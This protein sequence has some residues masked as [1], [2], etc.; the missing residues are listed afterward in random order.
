MA[1]VLHYFATKRSVTCPFPSKGGQGR[2]KEK[3]SHVSRSLTG[4]LLYA[5]SKLLN[6]LENWKAFPLKAKVPPLCYT[7][8]LEVGLIFACGW[9][10]CPWLSM[11]QA[12]IIWPI[13]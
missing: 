13:E 9:K 1:D 2:F 11:N 6:D 8:L 5:L 7:G 3:A 4:F 10:G 12:G